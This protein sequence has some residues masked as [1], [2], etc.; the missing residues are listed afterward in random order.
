MELQ[1]AQFKGSFL[2]LAFQ[3]EKLY[4]HQSVTK[5]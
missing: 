5:I 1:F 2:D 4:T 3:S